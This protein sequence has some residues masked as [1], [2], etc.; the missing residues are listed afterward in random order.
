MGTHARFGAALP[1]APS[2]VRGL[3]AEDRRPLRL[4]VH[5]LNFWP[6]LTGVAKYTFEMAEWFARRGHEVA[7]VTAPPY[8]PSWKINEGYSARKFLSERIAGIEVRRCPLYVP[9]DQT[10]ARRIVHALSFSASSWAPTLCRAV[11]WRPDLVWT[12]APSMIAA[13]TALAAARLARVP[14]W[15]HIQDLEADAAF[16]LGFAGGQ[17]LQRSVL[18]LE[19]RFIRQ[20]DR[21]STISEAMR[22][23]VLE[24][25]CRPEHVSLVP[26]W[27]DVDDIR[28]LSHPNRFRAELG[29][30]EDGVVALYSGNMGRK[31]GLP[32]VVQAAEKLAGISGLHFVMAGAGPERSALEAA[33]RHLDNFRFLPLQPVERL[34]ELL[35]MADVHLLP[36]VA[37]AADL[38]LPSKLSGMMA[39][40]RPVVATA[41]EGTELA[42]EV[43]PVGLVTPPGDVDRFAAAVAEL[44]THPELR[45]RL[46][47]AGR[48]RAADKWDRQMVLGCLEVAFRELA[49]TSGKRQLAPRAATGEAGSP[50]QRLA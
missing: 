11:R 39:S 6:D 49:Q 1:G 31:Q 16:A 42:R 46:G 18:A 10:A 28:P 13:G 32:I 25:G 21:I 36:Q 47:E 40:A 27:V 43:T 45:H 2:A 17:R 48:Q 29:I 20:F 26:N 37:H 7:V 33:A 12:V 50:P 4:L 8:Y 41:E 22:A 5:G 34:P 24:K 14:A 44:A 35:S 19:S 3:H 23:K 38:V 15:L 9:D 30:P